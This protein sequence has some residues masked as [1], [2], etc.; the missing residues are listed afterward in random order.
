MTQ[1][2]T[3]RRGD[4]LQA[5]V[6]HGAH[7]YVIVSNDARNAAGHTFLGVR[8]TSKNKYANA[9]TTAALSAGDGVTCKD[10]SGLPMR[11]WALADRLCEVPPPGAYRPAGTPE[12]RLHHLGRLTASTMSEIDRALRAALGL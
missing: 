12:P 5:D 7:F 6:G 1:P 11:G 3:V 8:I 4:V 9:P 2:F 10:P